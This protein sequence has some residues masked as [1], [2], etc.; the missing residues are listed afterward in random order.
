MRGCDGLATFLW[1]HQRYLLINYFS[2]YMKVLWQEFKYIKSNIDR[3]TS[4]VTEKIAV[5]T[6]L[7]WKAGGTVEGHFGDDNQIPSV[8]TPGWRTF[9][10]DGTD[11][12]VLLEKGVGTCCI[13]LCELCLFFNFAPLEALPLLSEVRKEGQW[14]RKADFLTSWYQGVVIEMYSI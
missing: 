13:C 3:D 8:C 5:G 14:G 12:V 1:Y 4:I 10:S 11:V 9:W 7:F 2:L 6:A